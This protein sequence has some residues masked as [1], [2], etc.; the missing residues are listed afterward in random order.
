MVQVPD[1]TGV[2]AEL[3]GDAVRARSPGIQN[4]MFAVPHDRIGRVGR[5][6]AGRPRLSDLGRL[7]LG[8][9]GRGAGA[10]ARRAAGGAGH[11]AADA[12]AERHR[13]SRDLPGPDRRH[14]AQERRPARSIIV[15]DTGI[16]IQNGKGAIIVMAGPT[17][18]RQQRRADGG[19]RMPGARPAPRRRHRHLHPRRAGDCRPRRIPRVLRVRP[20]DRDDRRAVRGR[21][22]PVQRRAASPR[23]ASPGSGWSAATRVTSRAAQPLVLMDSQ[24]ICAPTGTPLSSAGRAAARDGCVRQRCI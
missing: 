20:A 6:R 11:H 2:V 21:R 17:V 5:V 22:L 8:L 3:V 16:Y 1:V 7:L 18:D 13:R 12:A 10:G 19:L 14:H 23:R 4:G 24:S 15:N 9:G